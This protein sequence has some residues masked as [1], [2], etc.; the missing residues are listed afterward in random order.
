[1]ACMPGGTTSN[2]FTYFSK[3]NLALSVLM[4]VTST[5]FGVILIPIVLL[6][7]ATA[8]DLEIPR[9]NII[10]TLMVL[11]VPVAIGMGLRKLNAN[12]GA[13]TEFMGSVLALFFIA[14]IAISWVPRNWQF[15]MTTTPATY[16]AAIGSAFSAS[17]SATASHAR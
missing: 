8:L 9:E 7:Y 10:I 13:V 15:L 6:I 14:F 17:P 5:V 3:G 4:T 11:L 2:I 12:A 1:M 16:I